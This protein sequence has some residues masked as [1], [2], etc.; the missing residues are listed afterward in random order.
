MNA[1]IWRK[2]STFAVFGLTAA[3][4]AIAQSPQDRCAAVTR[5]QMPQTDVLSAEYLEKGP[6]QQPGGGEGRQDGPALSVPAHCVVKLAAHPTADSDIRVEI[7][8]PDAA[9]WNGKVLGIG[10]G[11]YSSSIAYNELAEGVGKGYVVAASNTGHEGE[12]MKFGAGHPEKIRDWGERATHLM[13][14]AE[15]SVAATLYGK[16][17]QHAY[18][19]GCSTG[20]QQALSEAQRY[21]EDYDGII[22]GDPANDRIL[23][24]ADF[25]ESWKIMHPANGPAFP[26]EKLAILGKAS[27]AACD[28]MDGVEDGV[29]SE[30][31]KCTFDPATIQCAAGTNNA[32]CLTD[33]EVTMVKEMYAGPERDASGK[34]IFPGWSKSS[35]SGWGGY[36]V[37]PSTPSRMDFWTA[38]VYNDPNLDP[39]SLNGAKIAA[40]ARAR[41]PYAEAVN[42]DLRP[43]EKRGGK[44]LMYHGWSDPVVPPEDSIL[45]YT[46]VEKNSGKSTQNFARLFM[47]PGMGHCTGGAGANNFDTL[48]ALDQWV[49]VDAAPAELIATHTDRGGSSAATT[50]AATPSFSRPLCPY[51]QVA[52]YNGKGDPNAAG[53]FTCAVSK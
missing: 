29:V 51:P 11:G 13:A 49:T 23:L 53:S 52:Q 38:W 50:P 9:A 37:R 25:V 40:D 6:F 34:A 12:D 48:T 43:F 26:L 39:H 42:T 31:R 3:G 4:A 46:G 7:W 22:A 8:L 19:R 14:L 18:F 28:K 24:N 33:A 5:L 36:F 41:I 47:V 10:N 1:T 27:V 16:S 17:A 2:A 45:Y 32:D 20:G 30:P 15:K 21:P 44:L 35:E